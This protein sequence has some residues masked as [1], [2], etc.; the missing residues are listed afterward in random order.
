MR[1]GSNNI[2]NKTIQRYNF[3][4]VHDYIITLLR[5]DYLQDEYAPD[6]RLCD[7]ATPERSLF[8][9]HSV[10]VRFPF[11]SSVLLTARARVTKRYAF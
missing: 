6:V 10:I 7:V 8:Q 4:H 3:L 2:N 9:W 11:H 1:P 5:C